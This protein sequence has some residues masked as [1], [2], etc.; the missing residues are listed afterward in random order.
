MNANL[1]DTDFYAWTRQQVHLLQTG[2]LNAL[3]VANLIDEVEDMGGSI[4]SQLESRLGVLLMHLLKWQFQPSHRGRSW[5][6]TIKEQRRRIERLL[7]N[8]PSLKASLDT[9]IEEAYGDAVLMAAKETGLDEG[10]FPEKCPYPPEQ[11]L[12]ANYLP[13]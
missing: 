10:A 6:L 1:H 2:Q 9:A 8:N 5:Q 7:R 3:D 12:Q 4:R 13:D 11:I